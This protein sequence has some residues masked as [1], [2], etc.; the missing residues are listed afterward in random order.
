MGFNFTAFG[1]G[2][3]EAAV[4]DIQKAEKLAAARGAAGVK[5]LTESYKAVVEENNK[6]K[7]ELKENINFLRTYDPTATEQ[8][9]F[10]VAKS[11]AF[12]GMITERVK[13]DDFDASTFKIS[14][15]AKVAQDNVQSTALERADQ[16]FKMAPAA[17]VA[18]EAVK[19]TGNPLRDLAATAGARASEQ[20]ARDTAAAMGVSLEELQAAKQYAKP[21]LESNATFNMGAAIRT[22]TFDQQLNDAQVALVNAQKSG[23]ANKINLAKADLLVFKTVKDSMSPEQTTFANKVADLKNKIAFGTPDEKKA[24]QGEFNKVLQIERQEALAKKT[25]DGEGNIPKLGTLNTFTSGAVARKVA[26]VH[27]DLIRS[28]Q[29]ALIEKPDGSVSLEYTGDNPEA[30]AKINNTAYDAAK[31]ALS[32]YTAPN[33]EPMTRDVAAVLNTYVPKSVMKTPADQTP[34]PA[35]PAAPVA[36]DPIRKEAEAAI[37]NGADRAA[38]AKRYKERTGKD[39]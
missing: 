21:V 5:Q 19:K 4:E 32:L 36:A 22:K 24:A 2:F 6:A 39:F 11:K 17:K 9:L 14:N 12:M 16:M 26:E 23:D 34:T 7:K 3:A 8:E 30:R 13:K 37:A 18:F 25:G 29:L 28:K 20:A 35:K 38:V 15:F 33:G 10:E 31:N 1:G 27:G